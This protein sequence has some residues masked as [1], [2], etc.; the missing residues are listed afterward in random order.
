MVNTLTDSLE[1]FKAFIACTD[2]WNYLRP[3]K[4]QLLELVACPRH[5]ILS[6]NGFKT[7]NYINQLYKAVTGLSINSL[8]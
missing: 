5:C 8:T 1:N 7:V 3:K 2:K 6:L 4:Y